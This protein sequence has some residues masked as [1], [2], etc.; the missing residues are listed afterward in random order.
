MSLPEAIM[1]MFPD[2]KDVPAE[3]IPQFPIIQKEYLING[4]VRTWDGE[5]QEVRSPVCLKTDG[6]LEQKLIGRYP[7]LTEKEALDALEAATAAYDNGRGE[8]PSI[9]VEERIGHVEKLAFL[10]KD[11]RTEII[12]LLMWEIGKSYSDSAKE[13]DRTIAYMSDTIDAL[14]DLDRAGSRFEIRD[15]I[16][17]QIRRAPLGVVLCMGPFNY[18]LNE[19][20][21]T[22]IPALI[23]GNTAIFKPPRIGVLL[24]RPLLRAF[25]ESFPKGVVNTVYG[26]GARLIAPMMA[27]GKIDVLAFIGSSRVADIIKK[28]HPKPHRLR[29]VLGLDAKN[30]GIILKDADIAQAVRECVLGSLSFNGQRCTA[31]KIIHVHADIAGEF[32]EQLGA[33]IAELKPGMP[34]DRDVKL[35]PLPEENKTQHMT[36]YIEDAKRNG[37][38]VVN[39]GGG[40]VNNTFMFPAVL[41]PVNDAMRVYH[42]EQFGP[43]IPVVPFTDIREPLDYVVSS[44]FGQQV[45]IFGSDPETIATLID[46]LVNQVCRVNINSQCQRGPDSFPFTGRKDSAEGTLS[47]SDALRV[48]S[49]RTLVAVKGTDTNKQIITDIL[50]DKRSNFLSTDFIF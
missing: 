48:F 6:V 18:P 5:M 41:Y 3:F 14:K 40:S 50:K 30:A 1:N 32:L 38:K 16:I 25:R 37:A 13:F 2:E 15:G 9:P 39:A 17:G 29:S 11:A 28:Q 49:I 10:M 45:S 19:T 27:T 43:V 36:D 24:H 8:W 34:W 23:M 44:N 46:T 7:V 22:L 31:L 42:E 33:A 47:V 20:F 4:E 12:N 26:D 35:T 21:T